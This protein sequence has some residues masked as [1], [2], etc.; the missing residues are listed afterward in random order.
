M[1]KIGGLFIPGEHKTLRCMTPGC[2]AE[3]LEDQRRKW[4]LHCVGCAEQHRE[5]VLS[6]TVKHRAPDLFDKA[7]AEYNGDTDFE[8]WVRRNRKAIAEGRLKM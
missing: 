5:E 7:S 3:F 2:G 4:E 1:L 6:Q 8:G